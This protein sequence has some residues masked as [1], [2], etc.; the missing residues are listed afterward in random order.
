VF[1]VIEIGSLHVVTYRAL[2]TLAIGVVYMLGFHRLY[3]AGFSAGLIL[4]GF[5]F[6]IAA[7]FMGGFI[8]SS[9]VMTLYQSFISGGFVWTTDFNILGV[10][11]GIGS[12]VFFYTR[13]HHLSLGRVFDLGFLPA[14]LG[15]AIGRLGCL[16]AGCC[17]GRV[18]DSWMGMYLP[19]VTGRWANRYPTQ[20]ISSLVDFSIFFFL[21]GF[22][23]FQIRR[24]KEAWPFPGFLFLLYV[25]LY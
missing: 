8:V 20:L 6:A 7:G 11:L 9:L 13:W 21:V 25:C 22:E 24:G 17:F 15:Q 19:D 5:G 16:A 14:P 12:V 18:T 10:L 1:P 23:R 4:K 2:I 3:R